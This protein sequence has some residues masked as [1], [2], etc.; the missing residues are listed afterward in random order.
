MPTRIHCHGPEIF[1]CEGCQTVTE[2]MSPIP[3]C[4]LMGLLSNYEGTLWN[5]IAVCQ[6][7]CLLNFHL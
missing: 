7:A 2:E 3:A 1:S 4:E 5:S 6:L